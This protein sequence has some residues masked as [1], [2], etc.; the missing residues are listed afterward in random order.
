M[1]VESFVTGFSDRGS[2]P[3]ASTKA[4]SDELFLLAFGFC[5]K[6]EYL[7][8]QKFCRSRMRAA[9]FVLGIG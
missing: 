3:L 7:R 2:T 1:L 5:G 4:E 6:S 9:V 8:T